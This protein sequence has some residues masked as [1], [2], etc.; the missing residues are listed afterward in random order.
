MTVQP[1]RRQSEPHS[2]SVRRRVEHDA[3]RGIAA[4]RLSAMRS[5]RRGRPPAVDGHGF[6]RATLAALCTAVLTA[7]AGSAA[8]AQPSAA[9]P[10]ATPPPLEFTVGALTGHRRLREYTDQGAEWIR[11]SGSVAGGTLGLATRLGDWRIGAGIAREAGR[12]DY[13]GTTQT[14]VPATSRTDVVETRLGLSA[15]RAFGPDAPV[16]GSL[17]LEHRMLERTILDVGRLSGLDETY[18]LPIAWLGLGATL[19]LRAGV[20][21]G[22]HG[23]FG[24]TFGARASVAFGGRLDAVRLAPADGPALRLTLPVTWRLGPGSALRLETTL[25]RIDLGRSPD[26]VVTRGGRPVGIAYQPELRLERAT[27]GLSWI[28]IW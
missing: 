3:K 6:G 12:L 7:A 26:A 28:G 11:E 1:E 10:S 18:R 14:G 4:G 13:R 22:L 15:Q 8:Q 21:V 5:G 17:A 9:A 19:P 24:H 25:E 23:E 20:S 27:L 16:F 2:R